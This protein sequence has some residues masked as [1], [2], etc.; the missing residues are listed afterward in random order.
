[1][2]RKNLENKTQ[3]HLYCSEID[4]LLIIFL[5]LLQLLSLNQAKRFSI[6]Y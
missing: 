2:S 6:G 1:M 4:N 3:A 5:K